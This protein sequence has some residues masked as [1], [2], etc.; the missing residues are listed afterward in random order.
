[1]YGDTGAIRA[2]ARQV[3]EQGEEIRARADGLLRAS[4]T[5]LWE[6]RAALAMQERM[7]ERAWALARTADRH[8][9]A[10]EA[11]LAHADRVDERKAMIEEIARK[12]RG[13]V[14]AA[15]SRIEGLLDVGPGPL[16]GMRPDPMDEL[17]AR[18]EEPARGHL[19]W[20]DVP[21][22]LPGIGR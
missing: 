17:L 6:G 20:L 9:I 14:S 18:F 22:L 16:P 1:M 19:D 2:H 8:R 10:S 3:G 12:V 13:M 7:R 21:D 15:R 5:V 4:L 11:L